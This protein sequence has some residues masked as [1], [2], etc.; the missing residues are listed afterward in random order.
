MTR[1]RRR[2]LIPRCR[3]MAVGSLS[4]MVQAPRLRRVLSSAVQKQSGRQEL[5]FA[6]LVLVT[7]PLVLTMPSLFEFVR[8]R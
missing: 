3:G 1:C 2:C 8:L 6:A 5:P 4:M 7:L